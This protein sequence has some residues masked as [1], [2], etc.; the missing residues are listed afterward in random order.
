MNIHTALKYARRYDCAMKRK[1]WGPG[2]FLQHGM[3]NLLR[4][5]DGRECP[6]AIAELLATDWIITGEG[7]H[8]PSANKVFDK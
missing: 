1:T 4:F 3:D 8:H 7:K 5:A 2:V 6:L